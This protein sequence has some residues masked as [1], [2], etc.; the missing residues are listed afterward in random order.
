LIAFHAGNEIVHPDELWGVPLTMDFHLHQPATI[1]Q[2]LEAAGFAVEEVAERE[3]YP[4][5]E[6]QSR[7]AYIFARTPRV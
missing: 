7:R 3:P 5:V 1:C 2:G 4:E 6:Y